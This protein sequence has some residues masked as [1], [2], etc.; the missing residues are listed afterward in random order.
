M[1]T[2][3]QL[4][5]DAK[6]SSNKISK[7]D[8]QKEIQDKKI[9]KSK[10]SLYSHQLDETHKVEEKYRDLK[11]ILDDKKEKEDDL[12]KNQ[13]E[14]LNVARTN[15]RKTIYFL[16]AFKN[17]KIFDAGKIT[18]SENYGLSAKVSR[19]S[20]Y[21][22]EFLSLSYVKYFVNRPKNKVA[23]CII[24]YCKLGSYGNGDFE[25]KI[26]ELDYTYGCHLRDHAGANFLREVKFFPDEESAKKYAIQ[27][28]IKKVLKKFLA[29]YELVKNEC[30]EINKN[31]SLEDFEQYRLE[32]AKK[33]F[34]AH[35]H[36]LKFFAQHYNIK[37]TV[38]EKLT[39][40]EKRRVMERMGN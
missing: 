24:G 26:L 3:K 34:N 2:A 9:S 32:K 36:N 25:T 10:Q 5:F 22:D 18:N 11:K 35:N 7:L 33:Y 38:W 1:K 28:P 16:R 21:T 30:I 14:K 8:K 4:L 20:A 12:H 19:L 31:Y 13:V 27:N 29:K 23:L 40:S 37:K 39:I 6:S 17:E 15:L